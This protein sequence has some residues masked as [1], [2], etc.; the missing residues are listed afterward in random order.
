M[1]RSGS[2]DFE[3]RPGLFALDGF[4]IVRPTFRLNFIYPIQSGYFLFGG[5]DA[6]TLPKTVFSDIFNQYYFL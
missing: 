5:S 3:S 2:D 4:I 1:G 6:L